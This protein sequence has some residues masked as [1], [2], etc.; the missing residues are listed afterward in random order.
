MSLRAQISRTVTG[1]R[2][3]VG[4]WGVNSADY[5]NT[6]FAIISGGHIAVPLNPRT[7]ADELRRVIALTGVR[8]IF[9]SGETP[10]LLAE[11]RDTVEWIAAVESDA[12]YSAEIL[13][14]GRDFGTELAVLIC[15]SGSSGDV[16]AAALTLNSLLN[17]A[18][19]VNAHLSLTAREQWL[20]CLPLNH[21]GGLAI[22]F[23]VL[24]A[25]SSVSFASPG[26]TARI[27]AL[28]DSGT[29]NVASLVSTMLR[30]LLDE[31]GDRPFPESV[32][33]LI[34]GGGSIADDLLTRC[35]VA[36]PTYGCT[37]A[38]SMI[39]CARMGAER[40]A[41]FSAGLPLPETR[42]RIVREDGVE[43]EKG[44]EGEIVVAGPGLF[45][46][47]W[48]GGNSANLSQMSGEFCTGDLG[49]FDEHGFLHV[50][51]RWDLQIK[52][53]GEK[54]HPHEI[55]KI[56]RGLA[57]VREAIVLPLDDPIW[58]Q[59]PGA[60]V[61]GDCA[62]LSARALHDDLRK[63]LPRPKVP[64]VIVV[65]DALP[66]LGNGKPDLPAIRAVLAREKASQ[67]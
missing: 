62:R 9:Y 46:G 34:V 27:A 39:S 2:S 50:S 10:W 23:R 59:V 4:V 22:L 40:V 55:E 49:W 18:R 42:I 31:R 54:I 8:T 36:L 66:L 32:R 33:A 37:E 12:D 5:R 51:G 6:L 60:F 3:C 21:I 45:A 48:Q 20:C 56:L 41:R 26:D 47:Y 28:L 19:A 65:A 64:A 35:A 17:H 30:R 1:T 53:G 44:E 14:R 63:Q 24:V 16:K 58:G 25:G 61:T 7:T 43:A 67:S 13:R 11:T 57:G 38:G 52:S 15:T 29:V